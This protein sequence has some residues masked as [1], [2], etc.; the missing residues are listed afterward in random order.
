M[1]NYLSK[2]AR[3]AGAIAL[4]ALAQ[5]H[6]AA[7][8]AGTQIGNQ[9]SA[10]YTDASNITRTVTSNVVTAVV[11]Q[12]AA[13]TLTQPLSKT[14]AIGGQVVYPLTLTNTGNGTDSFALAPTQAGAF[15]FSSMTLYADANGDGIADN[16]TPITG[17]PAL[18]SGEVF[19]FVAVANVPTTATAGQVNTLTV[20]ATSGFNNT[21][22][23]AVNET[24]TVTAN[25][26]LNVSKT[27]SAVSG[28]AGSGPY[29]VT[30]TYSNTGNNAATNVLLSDLLPAGMAYVAGSARW[31]VTGPT[32]ILTDAADGTQGASPTIAYDFGASA[33]GTATATINSVA[34][35]QSGTVSFQVNI[36]AGLPVGVLNNTARYGYHDGAAAVAA[37]DTNTFTF[38]VNQAASAT[39][40]GQTVASAAQG[41]TVSFV[42]TLANTGNGTDT[43]DVA[44]GTGFPAGSAYTLYKADGVSPLLDTNGNGIPDTGPLAAGATYNVVLKVTLASGA[45]GGPYSVSK[46]ATSA[47]NPSVVVTATDTLSAVVANTVD[48]TNNAA[49]A[50]APG[51]GAGVEASPVTT[52]TVLP[53]ATTRF[54]LVVN[55][56][57]SQGDTFNLAASTDASFAS[58]ALP[59]D[60]T[61]VFRDTAGTVITNTGV[62]AGGG[63]RVVYA[64]V[65]VPANQAALPTP[66]Q[67]L[68]FRVLSPSSGA[69]DRKHDAVVVQTVRTVQLVPSNT[70]QVYPGGSVV[71]AHTLINAGNVAENT[72]GANTIALALADSQGVFSSVLYLDVNSSN[73]IDAGDL[74]INTPADLGALAAGQSKRLLVRVSAV[75]GAGVGVTNTTTVTATTAGTINGSA[76]PAAVSVI[77]GT[78]VIAGNLVL[79]KEQ[80]L[81]AN[82]DGVADAAFGTA[83]IST[84]AIPGACIRY[85]ITVTNNGVADVTNVAVSDA[86]PAHTT[87]HGTIAA[88]STQG[89]VSAPAAGATGSVNVAVGTLTPSASVVVTFGVRINPLP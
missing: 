23:A 53:G 43:F 41:S 40:A 58:I 46:T 72:G 54:T 83:T 49:G 35:G 57:S 1:S 62:I 52:N 67:S 60:W 68:Y 25:A 63:N 66:G 9:A 28:N 24:T 21:V 55:N 2:L 6:A 27:M 48:L 82:C 5:A 13:L 4:L 42:N 18:A 71:Y 56:T 14:V 29:M 30:L 79:L 81:D 3:A 86:M 70:G 12:V 59:T 16:T 45:V 38:S 37:A 51:A 75:S 84:G 89:T 73:T 34:A 22:L 10:T 8:P 85:R 26:V 87:Y 15:S 32:V 65:T 50:G 31:S 7:P 77:D 47:F 88:A 11:Q 17:T 33:A 80:A 36:A 69:S 78:T 20:T 44:V 76:A 19:R 61:V 39:F 74:V 64:D